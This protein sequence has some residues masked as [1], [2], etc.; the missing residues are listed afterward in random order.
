MAKQTIQIRGVIVDG[1][2]DGEWAAEYI[3]RGLWTPESRVRKQLAD[4]AKAGDDVEIVISSQGGSVMSG[5]DMLAAI[6]EYP[7][8]K[9][10]TVGA[11]AASMAANIILQAGIPVKAHKNS[12]FLFHGAWG[13]TLGGEG[14]HTDTAA[15]LD[16]INEPIK[17]ALAAKGVPQD[18]IDA[19]FEEGRQYTM[20][21][22]QAKSFGIVDEII[23]EV[24]APAA[25]MTK[26]DEK[27]L[28]SQGATLDIAAC[29]AWEQALE[30][31]TEPTPPQQS[32]E[33]VIGRLRAELSNAKTQSSAV[34]SACDK[35]ISALMA[36]NKTSISDLQSKHDSL[37]AEYTAFRTQAE[38][39]SKAAT[40]R[41]SGLEVD[42]KQA[43][44]AHAALSGRALLGESDA[45][46]ET[47]ASWPKAVEKFGLAAAMKR[48]PALA[49][50]YRK[51]NQSKNSKGDK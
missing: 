18:Q 49:K 2:Y 40:D 34:Q 6:Q 28:L 14:A 38:S 8:A 17:Q 37:Q 25:K 35:R 26:D 27:A 30:P 22:E 47:P 41:I 20:T 19:G 42:L 51:N 50:E 31:P 39:D 32:S 9:S 13:V 10:I 36:E 3:G 44:D 21:A 23:G 5:N 7:H 16:Q 45:G 4:A 48:F 33:E 29:S 24:A 11:F 15:L 12:I 1:W 46:E 43:K